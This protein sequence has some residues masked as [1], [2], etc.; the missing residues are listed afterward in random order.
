MSKEDDSRSNREVVIS[1][2]KQHAT[3]VIAEKSKDI[4]TEINQNAQ[5]AFGKKKPANSLMDDDDIF[6]AI[7][8]GSTTTSQPV[9]NISANTQ[10]IVDDDPFGLLNLNVGSNIQQPK[11]VAQNTGFDMGLLGFEAPSTNISQSPTQPPVQSNSFSLLGGDLLGFGNSSTQPPQTAVQPNVQP[12]QN[13]GF[14][15]NQGVNQGGFN[16]GNNQPQVQ[17][18]Q[19]PTQNNQN[20]FLAY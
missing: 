3:T 9:N 11:P 12:Q 8:G 2:G 15:L 17:T 10:K 6:N 13:T 18:N 20:K 7:T 16:W 14:N 4:A 5:N 1:T 19:T